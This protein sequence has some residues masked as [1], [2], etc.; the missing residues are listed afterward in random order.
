MRNSPICIMSDSE[1]DISCVAWWG[2]PLILIYLIFLVLDLKVISL[3]DNF[4]S[5]RVSR[6]SL[7]ERAFTFEPFEALLSD[8]NG[9][10]DCIKVHMPLSVCTNFE[11]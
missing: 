8:E 10:E 5:E 3:N 11:I 7:D 4:D 1:N 6:N 9:E 2:Y